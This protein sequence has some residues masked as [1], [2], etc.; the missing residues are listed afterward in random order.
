MTSEQKIKELNEK[1]LLDANP[2][3]QSVQNF[4]QGKWYGLVY[5]K[6]IG[7]L[8]NDYLVIPHN[9]IIEKCGLFLFYNETGHGESYSI[10][11]NFIHYVNSTKISVVKK[12]YGSESGLIRFFEIIDITNLQEIV[13][14]SKHNKIPSYTS[15]LIFRSFDIY[16]L[17]I[18]FLH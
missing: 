9:P 18:E 17:I 3:F 4:K 13:F 16:G 6:K 11:C 8:P 15:N 10:T 2:Y 14:Y 7:L 5:C 12:D 1:Y